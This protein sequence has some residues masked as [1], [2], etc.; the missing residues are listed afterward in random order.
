MSEWISVK[1]RL[2]EWEEEVIVLNKS[3]GIY[4]GWILANSKKWIL[5]VLGKQSFAKSFKEKKITHWMPLSEPP[6]E[7]A[8]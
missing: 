1:D 2:P 5:L 7:Q 6:K 3:H 8:K 4:R